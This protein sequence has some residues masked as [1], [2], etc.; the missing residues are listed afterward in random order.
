M[1]AALE[2]KKKKRHIQMND[3]D[4]LVCPCGSDLRDKANNWTPGEALPKGGLWQRE[5]DQA[6]RLG[7]PVEQSR[8]SIRLCW[9]PPTP[10]RTRAEASSNE[11]PPSPGWKPCGKILFPESFHEDLWEQ[12]HCS[13][14]TSSSQQTHKSVPSV[15]SNYQEPQPL[16]GTALSLDFLS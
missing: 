1:G 9:V 12:S 14:R 3:L 15:R 13:F 5:Q 8:S 16:L 10:A 7:C 4:G 6:A 2:K 11:D